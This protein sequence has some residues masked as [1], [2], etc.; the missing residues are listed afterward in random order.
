MRGQLVYDP[1]T[2]N[3]RLRTLQIPFND[4]ALRGVTTELPYAR[5]FP[6][7]GIVFLPIETEH[8]GGRLLHVRVEYIPCVT[9]RLDPHPLGLLGPVREISERLARLV[10]LR[11]IADT[12]RC[13]IAKALA[14]AAL[15]T[16][17]LDEQPWR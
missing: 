1:N 12:A 13:A 3:E 4:P 15:T 5:Q 14:D 2:C 10:I 17:A 6:D 11:V 16:I 9:W 7:G 8:D